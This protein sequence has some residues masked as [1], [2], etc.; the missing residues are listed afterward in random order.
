MTQ[1]QAPPL[2]ELYAFRDT[3]AVR[4]FLDEHPLLI[5][6]LQQGQA[7]V[8]TSFPSAV[9][10]LAVVTDPEDQDH[11]QLVLFIGVESPPAAAFRQLQELDNVWGFEALHRSQGR[12]HINLE[13]R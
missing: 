13:F 6:L 9:L 1:L 4:R 5:P 10:S 7:R 8:R 11:R 2:E 12:F 3:D